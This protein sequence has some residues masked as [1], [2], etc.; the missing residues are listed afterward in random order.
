MISLQVF[1][2]ATTAQLSYHVQKLV[3]ISSVEFVSEQNEVS[4]KFGYDGKSL[5]KWAAGL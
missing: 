1:A 4:V 2:H 3:A 5:V